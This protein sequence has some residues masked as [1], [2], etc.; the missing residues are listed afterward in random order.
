MN[1]SQKIETKTMT[2]KLDPEETLDEQFQ[3]EDKARGRALVVFA[4]N[5]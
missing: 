5:K 3:K 1:L 2:I 4:I